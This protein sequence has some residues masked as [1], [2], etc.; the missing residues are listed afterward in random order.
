M[1]KY[2]FKD[3]ERYAVWTH[4]GRAC[5]WCEEPL[6]L[7]E[8]TVDHVIP[9]HLIEKPDELKAVLEKFGLPINFQINDFGNWLPC[10]DRCNKSKG[11]KTL[12]AVPMV[13]T[14]IEKLQREAES[15]RKLEAKVRLNAKRGD[16]LAKLMA[17]K[18]A[19]MITKEEVMEVFELE[20][21][22]GK[23]YKALY[24]A[25]YY[26]DRNKW[27]IVGILNDTQATVTDGRLAG[28]TPIGDSPDH[29]WVCPTCGHYGPWNGVICLTCG[30]R[31]DPF[32]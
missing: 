19:D 21:P 20:Y 17:A 32:D 10:H 11:G 28:I 5:Y 16:A 4:H 9:E 12:K 8:A 6:I 22:E 14:I 15:V 2:V 25:K 13:Q 7:Q 26:L 23:N 24:E 1:K 29:S 3:T 31:S 18:E 30:R 27:R